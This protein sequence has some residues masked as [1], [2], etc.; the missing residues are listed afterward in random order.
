MGVNIFG[1]PSTFDLHQEFQTIPYSDPATLPKCKT[2]FEAAVAE[3][4]QEYPQIEIGTLQLLGCATL[5]WNGNEW[6]ICP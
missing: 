5:E 6:V 1:D 2:T 4:T 3:L